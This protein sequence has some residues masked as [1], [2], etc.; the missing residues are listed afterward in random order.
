MVQHPL[1]LFHTKNVQ[2]TNL[3]IQPVLTVQ[4]GQII[5]IQHV[6]IVED[7]EVAFLM[8]GPIVCYFSIDKWFSE[9]ERFCK[10]RNMSSTQFIAKYLLF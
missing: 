9:K 8:S 2:Y 1:Q 5:H 7:A 6:L 3:V 4:S 10:K